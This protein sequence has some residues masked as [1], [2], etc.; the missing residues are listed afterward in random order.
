M[1]VLAKCNPLHTADSRYDHGNDQCQGRETKVVW[2]FSVKFLI[3]ENPVRPSVPSMYGR[4]QVRIIPKGY[5]ILGSIGQ[6][7]RWG[8]EDTGSTPTLEG[9]KTVSPLLL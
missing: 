9:E 2:W 6:D 8:F 1:S 4:L 5:D 3:F 7:F